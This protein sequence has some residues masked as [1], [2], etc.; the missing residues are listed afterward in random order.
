MPGMGGLASLNMRDLN[1]SIPV[2][3]ITKHQEEHL[4]EEALANR[5]T[6]FNKTS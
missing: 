6:D 2:V 3:M 5:I 4:M 1:I